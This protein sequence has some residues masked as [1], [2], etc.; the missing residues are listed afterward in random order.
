MLTNISPDAD[1]R[2]RLLGELGEL[3]YRS[4]SSA[5]Y[6]YARGTEIFGAEEPAEYIY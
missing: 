1:K 6:K 5:E 3:S 4:V 2:P